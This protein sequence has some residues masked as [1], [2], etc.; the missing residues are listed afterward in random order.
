MYK[1]NM[2][3]IISL[4]FI[5]LLFTGCGSLSKSVINDDFLDVQYRIKAGEDINQIDKWGWIPLHW[6]T[7][8][9]NYAMVKYLLENNANPN[10]QT[11]RDYGP[12]T[13]GSTPLIIAAYYGYKDITEILLKYGAN[14]NIT[15]RYNE[16]P[17]SIA[18]KYI[19]IPGHSEIINL[20]DKGV[21]IIIKSNAK[22]YD[23]VSTQIPKHELIPPPLP[24]EEDWFVSV[25]G[26]KN[27]PFKRQDIKE[28]LSSGKINS[29]TYIWREGMDKWET[30]SAIKIFNP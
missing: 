23:A 9:E 29:N 14:K 15:N 30:I 17:E 5:F 25:G 12:I 1:I 28:L 16:T 4:L 7:Y 8:Y 3:K 27:G 26:Q 13:E 21:P 10:K 2:F 6:A 19:L 20:I 18:K 11:I 24:Q 22:N